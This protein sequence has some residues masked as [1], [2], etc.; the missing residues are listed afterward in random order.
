MTA[1]WAPWGAL[2]RRSLRLVRRSPARTAWTAV[3][4]IS[5]VAVAGGVAS[6]MWGHDAVTTSVDRTLGAADVI[7]DGS[8]PAAG[9]SSRVEELLRSALPPGSV[10]S[11]EQTVSGLVL[12]G[13]QRD[14]EDLAGSGSDGSVRMAD[15]SD[16]LL[17]G[18]LQLVEGRAPRR[19][20]VVVSPGLAQSIGLDIGDRLGVDGL[21]RTLAVVGIGTVG[22]ASTSRSV[23]VVPGELVP[24]SSATPP[25]DVR[26]YVGLPDGATP[27]AADTI[28]AG[29]SPGSQTSDVT[30]IG[31]YARPGV[32][33]TGEVVT[34][35]LGSPRSRL[36]VI[37]AM[38]VVVAAVGVLAGAASAIGARRRMRANGL[39]VAIG[40]SPA[41]LAA[42]AASEAVIVAL[43]A[44]VVGVALSWLGSQAWI[45]LR[46]PG[47]PALIDATMNWAWVTLLVIGAVV[48]AGVGAVVFTRS[49]RHL[50]TSALLDG[51]HRV[52]RPA[53]RSL[54]IGWVGWLALGLLA[55]VVL[56]GVLAGTMGL[57]LGAAGLGAAVVLPALWLACGF[58][59]LRLT[60]LVLSRDP[61]GRVVDRDLRHRRLGSTATVVV[62]A[63]W[64]FVAVAGTATA[65]FGASGYVNDL[66]SSAAVPA[67]TMGGTSSPLAV[68]TTTLPA[69]SPPGPGTSTTPSTPMPPSPPTQQPVPLVP[70]SSVLVQPVS[71]RLSSASGSPPAWV[72]RGS[73]PAHGGPTA[74]TRLPDGLAAELAAA[75]LTTSSGVVGEWTGP[76]PVCPSGFTPTVLVLQRAEGVGLAPATVD[77]LNA[78][79]AVTPFDLA[80]IEDQ[81]V[82]GVPVRVGSIPSGVN[83]VLLAP[84]ASEDL[85]LAD[86]RPALVGPVGGL[87]DAQVGRII[88][89]AERERLSVGFDDPR[90]DQLRSGK[91]YGGTVLLAGRRVWIVWPL[92]AVLVVVTLA[93]TAAHRREHGDAARVLRV[94]GAGPRS[95]R[96]LASL[97]AGTLTG[98]GVV[99]GLTAALSVVLVVALRTRPGAD[100]PWNRDATAA[101][102]VALTLPWVVALLARLIPP[103]RSL[104]GP[105]GPMPA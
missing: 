10:V 22:G 53:G 78:G 40:A 14:G 29:G 60:R 89:I 97:T 65:G 41:H 7:Y 90:L 34:Q 100:G 73:E 45:R 98:T 33:G 82:A 62:V 101:L 39:L 5:A 27:P 49:T 85:R 1:W 51:R 79:N 72:L 61:I 105:D 81:T 88:D 37:A 70:G 99:I 12:M 3:L 52:T 104:D 35:L 30:L 69:T 56:G 102:V 83:A 19:G 93:A 25:V 11:V 94:L 21:S 8:A 57:F 17:R 75:G 42:A 71:D 80:G 86:P 103:Y 9:A 2:L 38:L 13:E 24:T 64:V 50:P 48:A 32:D 44:A 76:C 67:E 74:P 6:V 96:R 43:P 63:T 47:W 95:A 84:S 59:A 36:D 66:S 16:P 92:F 77:L 15:W 23:A 55:W 20:E 54:Q 87:S 28:G 46:V 31:P 4:V 18:V 91:D 26:A 68:P 58:G